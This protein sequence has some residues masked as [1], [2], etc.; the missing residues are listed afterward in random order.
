MNAPTLL[1]GAI[2]LA[3]MVMAIVQVG[4]IIYGARLARRVNR[5]VDVVE[6]EIQPVVQRVNTMSEDAARASSLAVAQVERVDRVCARLTAR[7]DEVMDT[8]QEAVVEPVRYVAALIQAL[9]VG[10]AAMRRQDD[11][12]PASDAPAAPATEADEASSVGQRR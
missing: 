2:A 7:V 1:L 12:P 11:P 5:L 6:R 8:A 4:M 10:V 9:R 3:T